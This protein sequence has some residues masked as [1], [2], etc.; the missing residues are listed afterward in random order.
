MVEGSLVSKEDTPLFRSLV[1]TLPCADV[2]STLQIYETLLGFVPA[3]TLPADPPYHW[4]LARCG[5]VVLMFQ[6]GPSLAAEF[7]S[8]QDRQPGGSLV[9]YLETDQAL[10]LFER[11]RDRPELVQPLR[12]T[13]QG[14]VEFV[15]A[16]PE[17]RLV[18]LVGE[19]TPSCQGP[20][21]PVESAP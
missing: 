7:P 10:P 15:L 4:A 18:V 13:S 19:R 6:S 3:L 17:G 20:D 2:T 16:D 11:L 5:E 21:L 14:K 9:L 12:E 1:P 8:L